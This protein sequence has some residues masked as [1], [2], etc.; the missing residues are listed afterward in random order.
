MWP[1]GNSKNEKL[2]SALK[3]VD[4][5]A[6]RISPFEELA[7]KRWDTN[8]ESPLIKHGDYNELKEDLKAIR[9]KDIFPKPSDP[10]TGWHLNQY[11]LLVIDFII[12]L[13][14][15]HNSFQECPASLK[16]QNEE[17]LEDVKEAASSVRKGLG[18]AIAIAEIDA[19][20]QELMITRYKFN[21]EL[22]NARAEN[23]SASISDIEIAKLFESNLE[24]LKLE[25]NNLFKAI[26]DAG[27]TEEKLKSIITKI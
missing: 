19:K 23:I 8:R 25:N 27:K 3:K 5:I 22:A 12:S 7:H 21:S 16:E 15:F 6:Q 1:F 9:N 14:E 2:I 20:V 13:M 18:I 26:A 17:V 10:S 24:E 4:S 11:A